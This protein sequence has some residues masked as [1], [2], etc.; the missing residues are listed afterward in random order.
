MEAILPVGVMTR[1]SES[2][3]SDLKKISEFGLKTCQLANPP[4]AY[5]YGARTDELTTSFISAVEETGVNATS[6]F[7]MYKGHRWNLTEGPETIGLV[8]EHTRAPRTVHACAVSNWA[9]KAGIPAVTSHMGFIPGDETCEVYRGF[10]DTMRAL[11]DF[12]SSNG[13]VFAFETGQE[14]P[15]VLKRTI[16]D[17]GKDGVGVNLDAANVVMYGMGTPEEAVEELGEYVLNTH[18]KDG[19]PPR[20][21]GKL[22]PE[23]PL[24][25]GS[26]DY[27]K[28]IPM[29]YEKG[30]RGPLTIEREISGER[31]AGDIRKA[32]RIL[33]SIKNNLAAA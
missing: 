33:E 2:P 25:E 18:I 9:K 17:I 16:R 10:I 11:V 32:V 30:F 13:Q 31:Q 19:M 12:F 15:R 3:L 24:G 7:I 4:D 21:E 28:L 5:I 27:K 26:V 14:T 29:L 1:I 22:G 23:T 20:E 6:V 8:P